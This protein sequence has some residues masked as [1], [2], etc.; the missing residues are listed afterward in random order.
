[1]PLEVWILLA[2]ALA[3]GAAGVIARRRRAGRRAVDPET[4][5]VYPL[6]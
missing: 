6:W 4:G 3:G 2:L 1:M 5:N